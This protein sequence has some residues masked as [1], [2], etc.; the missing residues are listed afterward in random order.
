[1]REKGEDARARGEAVLNLRGRPQ[2][3]LLLCLLSVSQSLEG[4]A[5]LCVVL[6]LGIGL[7]PWES[8]L[9]GVRPPEGLPLL[10]D[11]TRWFHPPPASEKWPRRFG[12]LFRSQER[13]SVRWDSQMLCVVALQLCIP[14]IRGV[15]PNRGFLFLGLAQ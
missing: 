5:L 7:P 15:T 11:R 3:G 13:W 14:N 6:P 2:R 8:H 12:N 10:C 4:R 1:M 9:L